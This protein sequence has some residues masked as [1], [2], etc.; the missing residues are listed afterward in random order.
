MGDAC[1]AS[2]SNSPLPTE[3][4][5]SILTDSDEDEKVSTTHNLPKIVGIGLRS[6]FA[7]IKESRT[8]EPSFCTKAL[9]A[10]LDVLQGQLPE[11]L[12]SEPDEVIDPLFDFL[13]DLATS[14]GPESDAA[15]DGSHLTAVACSCLLSLV[16]VRGD[17]GRLLTTIAALLMSPRA[18]TIQNIQLP[19]VLTSLQRSVH[20]VLVGKTSRPDW[21]THGVPKCSKIFT[22]ILKLPLEINNL[23]LNGRSFIS[24]GKYLYLHTNYGLLK[25]GSGHGGTIWGHIYAHKPDFYPSETGWIGYANGSLY[26]KFA[27]KKQCELLILDA[28]TL[29]IRGIAV[30]EGKDWSSSLMFSDGDNLGMITAG[31]DVSLLKILT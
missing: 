4:T 14:H 3:F 31:K 21:I 12:K 25:I 29:V 9:T 20:A 10:L 1:R 30:L 5:D 6:V 24:D 17:T 2:N 16:V 18:F 23:V 22:S 26:F 19:C 7:L 28:E 11:C 27:P 8:I 15:N 13:L